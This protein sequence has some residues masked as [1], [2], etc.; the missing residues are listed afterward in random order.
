MWKKNFTLAT[1][2]FLLLSYIILTSCSEADCSMLNGV[3]SKY[4][5]KGEPTTDTLTVLAVREGLADTTTLYK[6]QDIKTFSLPLSYNNEQ[7]KL[8]FV[9]NTKS[10]KK[11]TD[12]VKITKTNVSYFENISCP[13]YFLHKITKVENTTNRIDHI[14]IN[15]ANVNLDGKENLYIYFKSDN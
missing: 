15:N 5:A 2:F 9:F 1:S 10:G 6:L 11:I 8:K 13:A 7:D 3:R 14:D 12:I 4:V